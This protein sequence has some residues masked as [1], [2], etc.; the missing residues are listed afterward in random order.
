MYALRKKSPTHVQ[1]DIDR[2]KATCDICFSFFLSRQFA[3]F[4]FIRAFSSFYFRLQTLP[5][6]LI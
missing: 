1:K 3:A 6:S 5:S 2:G 4:M